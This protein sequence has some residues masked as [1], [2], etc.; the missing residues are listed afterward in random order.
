M[1]RVLMYWNAS[2][3]NKFLYKINKTGQSVINYFEGD[4]NVEKPK[5]ME[6]KHTYVGPDCI[7]NVF[8]EINENDIG[9]YTGFY[10]IISINIPKNITIEIIVN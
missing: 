5:D 6:L 10:E 8:K 7:T 2:E 3:T 1:E 9:K 4:K